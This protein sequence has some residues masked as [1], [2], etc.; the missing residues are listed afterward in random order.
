MQGLP[1]KT[2]NGITLASVV[3]MNWIIINDQSKIYFDSTNRLCLVII[4]YNRKDS[5][6]AL[7]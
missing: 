1:D 5:H 3:S 2:P 4:D 7:L 6:L